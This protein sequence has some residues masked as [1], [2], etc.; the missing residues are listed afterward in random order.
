[1]IASGRSSVLGAAWDTRLTLNDH[2]RGVAN[3]GHRKE[4]GATSPREPLDPGRGRI[5]SYVASRQ[6][7]VNTDSDHRLL[8]WRSRGNSSGSSTCVLPSSDWKDMKRLPVGAGRGGALSALAA[9]V[10]QESPGNQSAQPSALSRCSLR[11]PKTHRPRSRD[12]PGERLLRPLLGH[13]SDCRQHRRRGQRPNRTRLSM[14]AVRLQLR[15]PSGPPRHQLCITSNTNAACRNDR[16]GSAPGSPEARRASWDLRPGPTTTS[17]EQK[18]F[19]AATWT[20][21]SRASAPAAARTPIRRPVQQGNR[22]TTTTATRCQA[23]E[24]RPALEMSRQL[25]W[26]DLGSTA[27]ARST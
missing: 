5:N 16:T 11:G 19:D 20:S 21:S 6:T 15:C 12:L 22:R 4:K 7:A 18:A 25:L 3:I 14:G 27:P 2:S 1:V 17:D 26:D 13:L 23:L 9:S 10:S 8:A 24:L